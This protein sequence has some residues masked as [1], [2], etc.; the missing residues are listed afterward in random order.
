MTMRLCALTAFVASM[1]TA[2]AQNLQK[3]D[4]GYLYWH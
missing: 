3:G 2:Q 1:M 4:Y